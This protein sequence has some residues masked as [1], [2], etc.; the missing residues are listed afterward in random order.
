MVEDYWQFTYHT[1]IMIP[2]D[3][4]KTTMFFNFP[5]KEKYKC[6]LPSC[7]EN[8]IKFLGISDKI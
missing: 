5:Y 7:I 3:V 6:K 2:T 8:N 1:K 4:K